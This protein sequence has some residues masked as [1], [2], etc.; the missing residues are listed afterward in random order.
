MFYESIGNME[1]HNFFITP[2]G[3]PIEEAV[4]TDL[5]AFVENH[6]GTKV[7]KFALIDSQG[8]CHNRVIDV[9]LYYHKDYLIL[10]DGGLFVSPVSTNNC[11]IILN[12]AEEIISHHHAEQTFDLL[13]VV[14]FKCFEAEE[15]AHIRKTIYLS[16]IED[17]KSLLIDDNIVRVYAPIPYSTLILFLKDNNYAEEFKQSE[18]CRKFHE[19]L[20]QKAKAIDTFGFIKDVDDIKETRLY[21]D[22]PRWY[23]FDNEANYKPHKNMIQSY[24][25]TLFYNKR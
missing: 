21:F 5:A 7:K 10:D 11:K 25:D 23:F 18:K 6:F 12:A 22:S 14:R 19:M 15:L 8:G 3:D 24:E 9:F 2:Y 20:Y 13:N 4:F 16:Q 17:I 1:Y